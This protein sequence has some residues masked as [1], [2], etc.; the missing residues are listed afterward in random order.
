MKEE[1]LLKNGIPGFKILRLG[2][3]PG[4]RILKVEQL[5]SRV[6]Q[7]EGFFLLCLNK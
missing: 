5:T 1:K 3:I 2:A 4:L 7:L 6:E